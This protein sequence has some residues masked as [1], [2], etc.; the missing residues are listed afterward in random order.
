MAKN[1]LQSLFSR[2]ERLKPSALSVYLNVDQSQQANLNRGFE[3]QFNDMTL[4]I[5]NT[6]RDPLEVDRFASAVRHIRDF[7][8]IYQP[9]ARGL[10]MFFDTSDRFFWY[11]ELDF[12]VLNEARWDSALFSQPLANAVDQFER[13]GVVL[14]DRE[15]LRLLAVFLGEIEECGTKEFGP[16]RTRHIKTS[17]TDNIGSADQLQRKADEQIRA[18]L[19]HAVMFV[20]SFVQTRRV[21]RLLLAGT[22]EITAALRELLPK[23]LSP[24]VVGAVDLAINASV[25]EVLAATQPVAT[26]YERNTELQIVNTLLTAAAKTEKAVVGLGGT[27]KAVN[28][29]RVWELIYSGAFS[30]PGFECPKCSALFSVEEAQCPFCGGPVDVVSNVIERTVEHALR[31]GAKVEIVTGKA[32]ASLDSAGGIGAFLKTRTASI[33]A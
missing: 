7:V 18:N 25:A 11:R 3:T 19:R 8:S 1:E 9:R 26:E 28:S 16:G 10:A 30:S 24:L 33:R 20:D 21:G 4:A 31:K 22:P 6:I 17:G 2:P 15:H 13:Y 23:R 27:L 5:Q 12:P 29:N 14:V 32:A